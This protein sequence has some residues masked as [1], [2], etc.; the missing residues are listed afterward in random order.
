MSL[1]DEDS[2]ITRHIS[3]LYLKASFPVRNFTLLGDLNQ[4]ITKDDLRTLINE[5]QQVILI[6]RKP[7]GAVDAKLSHSQRNR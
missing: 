2:G 6:R 1:V 3:W 7:A 4:A 5:D